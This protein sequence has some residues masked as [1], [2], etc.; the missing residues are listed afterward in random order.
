MSTFPRRKRR[1]H[2]YAEAEEEM[3]SF[4]DY[5]AQYCSVLLRVCLPKDV[6]TRMAHR[7]HNLTIRELRQP[8]LMVIEKRR[9]PTDGVQVEETLYLV[10]ELCVLAGM[11]EAMRTDGG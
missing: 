11:T 1:E 3:V 2:K 5:Y 8:L 6:L 9:R 7:T 10:P 4:R